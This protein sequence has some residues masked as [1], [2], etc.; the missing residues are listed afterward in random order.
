MKW[1]WTYFRKYKVKYIIGLL[2]VVLVSCIAMINPFLAGY[3]VDNIIGNG[4]TQK[5]IPILA[6]MIGSVLLKGM[7]VYGYQ[8]I[9][10]YVSQDIVLDIRTSTYQHLLALDFDYYN[11]TK[12]GD[13]MARMTGD[14]DAIRHFIAYVVY[15]VLSNACLFIF[16]IGSMAM[17]SLPLTLSVLAVCPF[18]GFCTI[19]MGRKIG[20]TFWH[21]REAYA[22]LNSMVQENISGN[23]VIKAFGS[24]AYEMKKFTAQNLNYKE[25]NLATNDIVSQYIPILDGL[26]SWLGLVIILVGGLLVINKQMTM[27]ELVVFNSLLWALNNPMRAVGGLVNDT[28]RFIAG[29][30]KIRDLLKTQPKI[31]NLR[32]PQQVERIKGDVIFEHVSF[33]Y[34]DTDALRDVSFHVKPGQTVGIIGHTG[35]G[36]ST[37]VNLLSR[38]YECT[39]GEVRIDGI[40]VKKYDLRQLRNE[41]SIAMQDIFLF[42]DTIESNIAYGMPSASSLEVRAIATMAEADEFIQDMPEGYETIVGERGVGLSGGQKQR[43]ALARALLKNPSILILDDTT[44]AVDMETE[45]KIQQEMNAGQEKRT[46]FIIAHRISSVQNAD[47]ILVLENGHIIEQGT[48]KELVK[49][50]GYYNEVYRNQSGDFALEGRKA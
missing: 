33:R 6:L 28:Q 3:I 24:E 45:L 48:H 15:N 1:I 22:S 13:I 36:K 47:L 23:R 21:V 8:M 11:Q 50:S 38:F 10:E 29:S 12:T 14:T 40:D 44:S 32:D 41:I 5:L 26:A 43:I 30:A 35:A 2:L 19:K 20:P 18:I 39:S 17:I 49:K 7:V 31:K 46:T 42:S 4:Q 16:A 25:K 37:L 9:F 27:G 34:K